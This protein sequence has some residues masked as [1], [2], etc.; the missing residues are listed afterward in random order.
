[1]SVSN[2]PATR[3]ADRQLSGTG[4]GLGLTSLRQRAELMHGTLRAGPAP[5]GGFR[6]EAVL[7]AYVPTA[8]PVA[9][10]A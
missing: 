10:P 9:S 3:S 7:P 1:M 4:S 5:D 8:E 2:G 6:V